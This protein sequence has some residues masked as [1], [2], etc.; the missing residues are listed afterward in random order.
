MISRAL[1]HLSALLLLS[2]CYQTQVTLDYQPRPA[3]AR[4]GPAEYDVGAVADLRGVAPTALGRVV[5]SRYGLRE[6]ITLSTPADETVRNALLHGMAS[7]GMLNQRGTAKTLLS[8]E[9]DEFYCELRRYPYAS[10]KLRVVARSAAGKVQ[11]QAA[12]AASRQDSGYER[13]YRDTVYDLKDISART[14]QDAVDK[15]LDDPRLHGE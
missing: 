3:S 11:Y 6:E 7:R 4:S 12:Y 15:V 8:V 5:E 14:L 13:G 1:L 2:S 10:C 9:V